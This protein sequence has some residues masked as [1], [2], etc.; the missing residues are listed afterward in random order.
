[1]ES[2]EQKDLAKVAEIR[3]LKS[4]IKKNGERRDGLEY[5][6]DAIAKC[7]DVLMKQLRELEASF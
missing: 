1:M 4:E 7:N 6:I 2:Q 3:R 5:E